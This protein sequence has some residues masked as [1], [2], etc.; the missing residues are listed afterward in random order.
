MKH[1][2]VKNVEG[3]GTPNTLPGRPTI[4]GLAFDPRMTPWDSA[5]H[6]HVE[7]KLI[8]E[9]RHVT[10]LFVRTD[11]HQP[12]K[13]PDGTLA[14]VETWS[15]ELEL[16]GGHVYALHFDDEFLLDRFA[17]LAFPDHGPDAMSW[18]GGVGGIFGG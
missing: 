17:R 14:P 5:G 12:R 3:V 13:A 8:L 1:I 4:V 15:V 7:C 10:S 11:T 16:V 2:I 18:N 6:H 9:P